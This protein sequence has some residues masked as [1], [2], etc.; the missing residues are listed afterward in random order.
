MIQWKWSCMLYHTLNECNFEECN[1]LIEIRDFVYF[2]LKPVLSFKVLLIL[3]IW[4]NDS[5]QEQLLKEIIF[6]L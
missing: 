5:W 2:Y 4:Q 1:L 6:L 3:S